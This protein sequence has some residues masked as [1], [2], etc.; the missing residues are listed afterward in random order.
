MFDFEDSLL[1]VPFSESKEAP[2]KT[3]EDGKCSSKMDSKI[4]VGGQDKYGGT[5]ERAQDSPP[6]SNLQETNVIGDDENG[7]NKYE[8]KFSKS[9]SE[10]KRISKRPAAAI[11]EKDYNEKIVHP[12]NGKKIQYT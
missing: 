4:E 3:S 8:R 2:E 11:R 9:S 12:R 6:R 7:K 10:D 5:H 1:W